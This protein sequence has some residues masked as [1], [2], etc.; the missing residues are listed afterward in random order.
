MIHQFEKLRVDSLVLSVSIHLLSFLS[1]TRLLAFNLILPLRLVG[2]CNKACSLE[3]PVL[4]TLMREPESSFITARRHAS[5]RV[6]PTLPASGGDAAL[7]VRDVNVPPVCIPR[8]VNAAVNGL[9]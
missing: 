7:P 6:P 5:A 4:Q 8:V 1:T 3:T 2:G 9:P